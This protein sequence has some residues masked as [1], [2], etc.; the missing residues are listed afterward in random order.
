MQSRLATSNLLHCS[1]VSEIFWRTLKRSVCASGDWAQS[2]RGV[3]AENAEEFEK[4][5]ESEE[6]ERKTFRQSEKDE[7]R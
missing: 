6:R 2:G 4:R 3:I 5:L 1:E 7:K